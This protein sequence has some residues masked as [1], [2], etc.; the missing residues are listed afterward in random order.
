MGAEIQ[1]WAPIST[2]TRTQRAKPA[3]AWHTAH[4]ESNIPA[5]LCN[6]Q[7]R[8]KDSTPFVRR[9]KEQGR[10]QERGS[11]GEVRVRTVRGLPRWINLFLI[12]N[13]EKAQPRAHTFS[14]THTSLCPHPLL[15]QAGKLDSNI[16]FFDQ[17]EQNKGEIWE[18]EKRVKG[19]WEEYVLDGPH[20]YQNNVL[21]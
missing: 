16:I 11:E 3:G 21:V 18:G 6:M 10:T 15:P 5:I 1:M 14:H 9:A 8:Q 17:T 4:P 20:P 13:K 2:I 19:G 7:S 12:N